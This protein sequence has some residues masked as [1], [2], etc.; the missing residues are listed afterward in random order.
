MSSSFRHAEEEQGLLG[1]TLM[2]QAE[3]LIKRWKSR[4]QVLPTLNGQFHDQ[5]RAATESYEARMK[6]MSEKI[7]SCD[8]R[9]RNAERG[10]ALATA[11]R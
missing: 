4:L 7:H 6:A 3:A 2:K 9:L 1:A 8:S 11:G 10:I 5:V